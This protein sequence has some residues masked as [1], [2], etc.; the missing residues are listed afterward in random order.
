MFHSKSGS[1]GGTSA[2]AHIGP[3]DA[4]PLLHGYAVAW[5]LSLKLDSGGS[6]GMSTQRP[7]TS[8][9]QP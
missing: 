1:G 7:A 2:R 8:N 5:T 3:D 9:F 6:F 4:V